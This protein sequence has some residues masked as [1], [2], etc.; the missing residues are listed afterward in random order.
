MEVT[1]LRLDPVQ[2][3]IDIFNKHI[4]QQIVYSSTNQYGTD[5]I[6]PKTLPMKPNGITLGRNQF[7][8]E[9]MPHLLRATVKPFWS[10]GQAKV[11][12]EFNFDNLLTILKL[13]GTIQL[14][15]GYK[16]LHTEKMI[17][18]CKSTISGNI[19][20]IGDKQEYTVA[21]FEDMKSILKNARQ[22]IIDTYEDQLLKSFPLTKVHLHNL[23]LR[24]EN[25]TLS[26]SLLTKMNEP[27]LL[28]NEVKQLREIKG[29]IDS[30]QKVVYRQID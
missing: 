4:S 25:G 2:P 1:Y 5:V 21:Q 11:S 19:Y 15:D 9:N 8:S 12:V 23:L 10:N 16:V 27:L 6:I 17:I 7:W 24:Y 3:E 29:Y 20:T 18:L 22:T 28:P 30:G 14:Q 26:R 13:C